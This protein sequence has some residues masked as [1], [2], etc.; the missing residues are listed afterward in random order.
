[1]K[2]SSIFILL[3]LLSNAALSAQTQSDEEW[4]KEFQ[5]CDS[6]NIPPKKPTYLSK[7]TT[8]T[9]QKLLEKFKAKHLQFGFVAGGYVARQGSGQHIAISGLVGNFY[10]VTN[11]QVGGGLV[12]LRY[13]FKS[14]A[15][16]N[17]EYE[18]QYSLS[19]YFFS[20]TS[21]L[22][23]VTQ[24][25]LFTN[26]RYQYQLSNIPTYLGLKLTKLFDESRYNATIDLGF[27]VNR[28][29]TSLFYEQSLTS[30]SLPD[31]L[32]KGTDTY[33]FT[34]MTGLGLKLKNAFGTHPLECGYRFFYLGEGK[35]TSANVLVSDSLKTG[36]NYANV[37]SCELSIG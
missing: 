32:F 13:Y 36:L 35:L 22:G 28:L 1:M 29:S 18:L 16:D 30:Y 20:H 19:S 2:L 34:M 25:N 5:Q 31:L 6:E 27:G 3:L 23:Y 4:A 37:I 7:T 8:S 21:V 11:H 12:G 10:S 9:H 15:F 26:L 33:A 24:E 17:D 14:L